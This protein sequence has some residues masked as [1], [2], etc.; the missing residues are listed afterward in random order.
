MKKT[1]LKLIQ[2]YQSVENVINHIDELTPGQQKKIISH[3]DD[4]KLSKQL[5][6]IHT[7]VPLDIDALFNKMKYQVDYINA[8]QI[9]DDNDL[10]VS[11]KFINREFM[12]F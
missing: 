1:A 2:Q 10:K 3:M 7:E 6:A 11:S 8:I 12:P 5:A 9:C 4:L